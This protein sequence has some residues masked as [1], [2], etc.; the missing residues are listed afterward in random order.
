[1]TGPEVNNIRWIKYINN[2]LVNI[3]IGDQK[4]SGDLCPLRLTQ[5]TIWPTMMLVNTSVLLVM[6]KEYTLVLI[7]L[8]SKSLVSNFVFQ[9]D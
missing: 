8:Q 9:F 4:F 7:E 1:M 3:T 6:Q 2:A 5:Y